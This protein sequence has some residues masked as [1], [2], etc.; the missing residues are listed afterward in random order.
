MQS[1]FLA[2]PEMLCHESRSTQVGMELHTVQGNKEMY[3]G[4]NQQTRGSAS[5]WKV[6]PQE[7]RQFYSGSETSLL[8]RCFKIQNMTIP[9]NASFIQSDTSSTSQPR[10]LLGVCI[11]HFNWRQPARQ[12]RRDRWVST[13]QDLT[14]R[15]P[16]VS[17][18]REFVTLDWKQVL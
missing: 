9:A 15:G 18:A 14:E 8:L 7:K 2:P 17:V 10:G 13:Y 4:V 3:R 6:F 11:T 16:I 1:C 12:E 5:F